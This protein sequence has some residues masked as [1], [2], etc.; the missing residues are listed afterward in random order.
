MDQTIQPN[1]VPEL[2][3]ATMTEVA[4]AAR[5]QYDNVLATIRRNP[6]Q[7]VGI[8]AGVGF[9]AALLVRN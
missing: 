3:S 1:T 8:A 5:D 7:A 9:V 4:D 6:L 2:A